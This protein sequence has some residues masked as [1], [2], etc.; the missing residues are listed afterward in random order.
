MKKKAEEIFKKVGEAYEILSDK[1]KRAH[2]DRFGKDVPSGGGTGGSQFR[3]FQGFGGSH[4]TFRDADQ[5]FRDFFG[6][7]DPFQSF[8][9]ED[10]DFMGGFGGFGGGYGGGFGQPKMNKQS[11]K[12]GG[13]KK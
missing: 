2:Y 12:G 1:D 7:K 5:I 13:S 3:G 9:D 8:H 4:F 11:S 10:D 6:G